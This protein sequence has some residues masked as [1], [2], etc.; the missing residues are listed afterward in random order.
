MRSAPTVNVASSIAISLPCSHSTGVGAAIS[1]SVV[2]VPVKSSLDGSIASSTVLWVGRTPA[3]RRSVGGVGSAG[4]VGAAA[5]GGAAGAGAWTGGAAAGELH[6]ASAAI[7]TDR[8]ERIMRD[9]GA[10]HT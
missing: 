1:S 2:I 5:V 7:V 10:Q 3:G 8:T 9:L 4:G 6:A